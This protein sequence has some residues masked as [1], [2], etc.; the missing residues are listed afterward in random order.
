MKRHAY[1]SGR[2]AIKNF[3][4]GKLLVENVPHRK[5]A[6]LDGTRPRSAWIQS[7]QGVSK[8]GSQGFAS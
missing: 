7:T 8:V 1:F 3:H 2:I 4:Q 5:E 6:N